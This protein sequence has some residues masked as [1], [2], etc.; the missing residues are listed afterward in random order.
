MLIAVVFNLPSMPI[1]SSNSAN[2]QLACTKLRAFSQI[3][4]I[5]LQLQ[6]TTTNN[7]NQEF[8]RYQHVIKYNG[9][10]FDL[11]YTNLPQS[12]EYTIVSTWM[13][14]KI[15]HYCSV[16]QFSTC[17]FGFLNR[18]SPNYRMSNCFLLCSF[19]FSSE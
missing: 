17:K 13:V 9:T 15:T 14:D 19:I 18:L 16:A 8:S 5:T 10:L 7:K 1:T 6:A 3:D 11:Q 12:T 4:T 2:I